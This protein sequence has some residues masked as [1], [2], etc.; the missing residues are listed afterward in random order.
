MVHLGY[1]DDIFISVYVLKDIEDDLGFGNLES[2]WEGNQ[3]LKIAM[4][5]CYDHSK[6]ILGDKV[7]EIIKYVGLDYFK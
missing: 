5:E 7:D 6:E 2:M 4:D 1:I 3:D